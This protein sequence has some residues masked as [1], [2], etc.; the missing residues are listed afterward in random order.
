MAGRRWA[1]KTGGP[2]VN[3]EKRGKAR[4]GGDGA[5]VKVIPGADIA[6]VPPEVS[7]CAV[8][9]AE[10]ALANRKDG[11][12]RVSK[13]GGQSCRRIKIV[14]WPEGKLGRQ[15]PGR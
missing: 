8:A 3:V 14:A 5:K 2:D 11:G 6:D 12:V 4:N 13:V 10:V 1:G 9:I 15:P 7:G